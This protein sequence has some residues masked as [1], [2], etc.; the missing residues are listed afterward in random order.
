MCVSS[1]DNLSKSEGQIN[2]TLQFNINC[3]KQWVFM[4]NLRGVSISRFFLSNAWDDFG[5]PNRFP[6][7]E[8]LLKKGSLEMVEKPMVPHLRQIGSWNQPS[9]GYKPAIFGVQQAIFGVHHL[10]DSSGS[11]NIAFVPLLFKRTKKIPSRNSQPPP[12]LAMNTRPYQ[13]YYSCKWSEK[14]L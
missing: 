10:V 6:F 8:V 12:L 14:T 3:P 5:A 13:A 4:L 11:R 2:S 9:S 1:A 7:G